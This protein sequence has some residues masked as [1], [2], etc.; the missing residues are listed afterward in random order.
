M[1]HIDTLNPEDTHQGFNLMAH[2]E[3]RLST[4]VVQTAW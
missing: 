2:I 1:T 4:P 3:L